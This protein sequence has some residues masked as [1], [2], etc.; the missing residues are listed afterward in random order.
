MNHTSRQ[1]LI[2]LAEL[3][4]G[5]GDASVLRIDTYDHR[6]DRA[7]AALRPTVCASSAAPA[8]R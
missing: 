3:G 7:D 1:L 2:R 8:P 6:S 5:P 4:V